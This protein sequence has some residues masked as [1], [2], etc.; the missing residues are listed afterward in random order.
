M[1]E[2]YLWDRSGPPDPEIERIEGELGSLRYRFDR[3][4]PGV[5]QR[6]VRGRLLAAAAAV[7][8]AA[9]ALLFRGAGA[10]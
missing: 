5:R 4:L 3:S 8:L 1:R 2:D 6:P 9:A 10:P 7:L